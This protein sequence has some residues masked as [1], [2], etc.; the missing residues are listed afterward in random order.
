VTTVAPLPP[1]TARWVESA[2]VPSQI[3]RQYLLSVDPLLRALAV[4]KVGPLVSAATDAAAATAGVPI[5]GL[6]HNA[7]AVRI[8]LV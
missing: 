5:G 6:Y 7:G 8:R 1:L 4:N 3:W 2:G